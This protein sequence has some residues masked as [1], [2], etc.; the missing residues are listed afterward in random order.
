[1]LT[2]IAISRRIKIDAPSVDNR[3]V[4][5]SKSDSRDGVSRFLININSSVGIRLSICLRI[6]FR[7]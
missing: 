2:A 5:I 7:V 4:L 3:F 1:M 6:Y